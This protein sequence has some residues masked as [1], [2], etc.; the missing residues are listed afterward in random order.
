MKVLILTSKSAY[1]MVSSEAKDLA[2]KTGWDVDVL[3]LE[4]P[5]ALFLDVEKLLSLLRRRREDLR[6]YDLIVVPGGIKGDLRV[7]EE[8]YGVRFVKGPSQ[9]SEIS[10]YLSRIDVEK[11]SPIKPAEQVGLE[12]R[13]NLVQEVMLEICE[14]VEERGYISV[15]DLKVP[16]RPP[17]ILI[18]GEIVDAHIRSLDEIVEEANYMSSMGASIISLGFGGSLPSPEKVRSS[19]KRVREE[20]DTPLAIDSNIPSEINSA[21][22]VGVD[23]VLSVDPSITPELASDV[24]EVPVVLLPTR[25]KEGIAPR[26]LDEKIKWLSIN[27]EELRKDGFKKIILDP[28]LEPPIYPGTLD[29]LLAYK[30]VSEKYK[31]H[32]ILMGVS[33]VV[34]LIDSDSPGVVGLLTALAGEAGVSLLLIVEHS[35]KTRGAIGEGYLASVQTSISLYMSRPP[36]DL[37][38]DTLIFKEKRSRSVEIPVGDVVKVEAKDLSL[39]FKRDPLGDFK[40]WIDREKGRILALYEGVKGRVLI[41]GF[42]AEDVGK[43]AIKQG[44]VSELTHALYLGR[45]LEKAELAIKMGRSYIQDEDF[46]KPLRV[47]VEEWKEKMECLVRSG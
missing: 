1:K 7:L 11:L 29:S 10:Y 33:N 15:G 20:V 37:G 16:I 46:F 14:S 21:V 30:E 24:R 36:K 42:K 27:L 44:L 28:I 2:M 19:I 31:E 32:P 12:L 17:P 9:A 45:E 40:I 8:E 18:V 25:F 13:K 43:E 6:K 35:D 4:V 38:V 3:A 41:E 5:V 26:S 22:D 34:E 23:L 39:E 47:K